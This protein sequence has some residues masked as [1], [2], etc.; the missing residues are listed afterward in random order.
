MKYINYVAADEKN[1]ASL[2]A[3]YELWIPYMREIYRDDPEFDDTD[4]E[5]K[6]GARQ[7]VM[8]AAARKDMF[9]ELVIDE[10]QAYVGFLFY[11]VD[12]GGIPGVLPAGLGYIMEVYVAPE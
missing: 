5:L 1:E 2:A 9:F 4:E 3:L 8:A 7:R 6:E 12:H 11:A 10:N